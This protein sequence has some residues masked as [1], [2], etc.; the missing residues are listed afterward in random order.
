MGYERAGIPSYWVIDPA[1][2]RLIAWE[3]QDGRYVEVADVAADAEWTASLPFEVVIR[4][5]T[6]LD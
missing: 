6:P 5:G 2:L 4:P 3:L 1:E